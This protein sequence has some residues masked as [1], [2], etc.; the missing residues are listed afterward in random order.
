M[1]VY[2]TSVYHRQ[3]NGECECVNDRSITMMS[4]RIFGKP[5][6]IWA[7]ELQKILFAHRISVLRPTGF[8]PFRLLFKEE[9]MT[10]EEP[11]RGSLRVTHQAEEGEEAV[12]KELL[13]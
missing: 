6:G 5:K 4:K 9:S 12:A 13:E 7:D 10:L 3:S 2:F 11:S 1:K 8:T